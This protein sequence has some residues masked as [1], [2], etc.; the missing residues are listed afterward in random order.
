M[1]TFAIDL[2][3]LRD[4]LLR[5]PR[6]AVAEVQRQWPSTLRIRVQERFPVA[7][8]KVLDKQGID[9]AY[10]L[11]E[12]GHVMLPFEKG[13][14]SPEVMEAEAV[15]PVLVGAQG[16]FVVGQATSHEGVRAALRWLTEYEESPMATLTDVVSVDVS[17]AGEVEA[18]TWLGSRV[19]FGM[20]DA[21]AGFRRSLRCWE[22]IHLDSASRGRLIGTLDLS[23][24]NHV[25][26]RWMDSPAEPAKVVPR[27]PKPS[28][29]GAR[30]HG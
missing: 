24:T 29:K 25:P 9:F 5:H 28:R 10:L 14:A 20:P 1:N 21:G 30:R 3:V 15:L 16:T 12:S 2:P 18:R 4:H 13:Q 22:A 26:L 23:V 17:R 11:D 19:T 6:I 27:P 8:V 7:R